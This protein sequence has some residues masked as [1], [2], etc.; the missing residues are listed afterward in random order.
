METSVEAP[1]LRGEHRK[2]RWLVFGGMSSRIKGDSSFRR[3]RSAACFIP[4]SSIVLLF[5][6]RHRYEFS[7]LPFA[8]VLLECFE[9]K[10][11]NGHLILF[12]NSVLI[13]MQLYAIYL[14]M[15]KRMIKSFVICYYVVLFVVNHLFYQISQYTS[16]SYFHVII[17]MINYFEFIHCFCIFKMKF[18]YF[19]YFRDRL[20]YIDVIQRL[21]FSRHDCALSFYPCLFIHSSLSSVSNAS[22]E[23]ADAS[24][25]SQCRVSS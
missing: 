16:Y 17:S 21:R 22:I 2:T 8:S 1:P 24:F 11:S 23:I 13:V 14:Y 12:N 18:L 7:Y 9:G 19:M 4:L 25:S 3:Q 15:L 5:L 10:H 6:H 20:Q